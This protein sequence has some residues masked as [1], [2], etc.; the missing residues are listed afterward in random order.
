VNDGGSVTL[1]A[2]P[3]SNAFIPDAWSCTPAVSFAGATLTIPS[4]TTDYRCTVS[5]KPR[6]FTV[7]V[8]SDNGYTTQA[9]TQTNVCENGRCTDV[10]FNGSVSMIVLIDGFLSARAP[11]LTRWRGCPTAV[12]TYGFAG[13]NQYYFSATL[14]NVQSNLTCV[15]EFAA[16]AEVDAYT[17][18]PEGGTASVKFT[19]G[20]GY[21]EQISNHHVCYLQA[22]AVPTLSRTVNNTHVWQGWRCGDNLNLPPSPTEPYSGVA[23]TAGQAIKCGSIYLLRGPD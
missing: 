9:G 13:E 20:V 17:S 19:G 21:C 15:A 12:T 23:V 18:P 1:T 7:S 16:A 5:F 22:G 11:I 6:T 2:T 3:S 8:S 10:P 4:V 14:D